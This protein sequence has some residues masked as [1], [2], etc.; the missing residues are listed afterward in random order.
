MFAMQWTNDNILY[1]L[2]IKLSLFDRIHSVMMKCCAHSG[3]SI[4]II[5]SV[6]ENKHPNKWRWNNWRAKIQ[7]AIRIHFILPSP[8]IRNTRSIFGS[9]IINMFV[10][11]L[12]FSALFHSPH[13]FPF[14]ID[15]VVVVVVFV[16]SFFFAFHEIFLALFFS[17]CSHFHSLPKCDPATYT[18]IAMLF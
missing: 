2:N 16:D 10:S 13:F 15:V 18:K 4:G 14:D 6:P 1:L 5:I 9:N 12:S 7:Y 3:T 17:I 8:K 11:K